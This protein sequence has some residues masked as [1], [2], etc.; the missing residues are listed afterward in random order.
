MYFKTILFI[1]GLIYFGFVLPVF[2]QYSYPQITLKD[3]DSYD[4]SEGIFG[5]YTGGDFYFAQNKFWANNVGQ[6]GITSLGDIG[7]VSLYNVEI[8]QQGFSRF[9][10]NAEKGHTYVSLARQGEEGNYI[11]FRIDNVNSDR[12]ILSYAYRTGLP[13]NIDVTFNFSKVAS[14]VDD[15]RERAVAFHS[16]TYIDSL[17]QPLEEVIFGTADINTVQG[18]GWYENETS[19]QQ[20]LF[21]WAGG[22]ALRA[23]VKLTVPSQTKGLLLKIAAVKDSIMMNVL[24]DQTV[25]DTL[26]VDS[27]WHSGFV[28][29]GYPYQEPVPGEQPVWT[30]GRYFPKFQSTDRIFVFPALTSIADNSSNPWDEGWRINQSY[31]DLMALTLVGMQGLINRSRPRVYLDWKD[32]FATSGFWVSHIS[33]QI[34][35]IEMDLD[36]L[37]AVNFL[38]KRFKTLFKGI[39]IYDPEIP[40]TINLATMLAGKDDLLILAPEQLDLPGIT[41]LGP[42]TDLQQLALSQGW[43][44]SVES[45]TLIYQWAYDNIWPQLEHRILGIITPGPPTSGTLDNNQM[46]PLNL[47]QRDYYVALRLSAIYL[48]PDTEP[49]SG[50]LENFFS[51]APSPVPVTGG[52]SI[53]EE[54]LTSFISRHGDWQMALSWPGQSLSAGNLSVFSG[55]ETDVKKY[56]PEMDTGRIFATLGDR[57][58]ATMFCTDGDNLQY[59]TDR[60]FHDFFVWEDVQNQRFGWTINPTL[61]EIAPIVWNYYVENR[62]DVSLVSGLSGAGY[63]YPQLMDSEQLDK[64]LDY[65][66]QYFSD[67]GLRVN[68]ADDRKGPW[69]KQLAV[70]YYNKL[71]DTGYMGT[72]A[73]YAGGSRQGIA[74]DYYGVPTPS[75]RPGYQIR[76]ENEQAVVNDI[77]SRAAGDDIADIDYEIN[78]VCNLVTD[79]DAYNNQAILIPPSFSYD[80][81]CCLATN[82]ES[83]VLAPGDY[84]ATFRLKV[85]TNEDTNPVANIYLGVSSDDWYHIAGQYIA[86]ADFIQSNVYQDFIIPF[87]LDTLTSGFECRIDHWMG[88]QTELYADYFKIIRSGGP[89][90][91]SFRTVLVPLIINVNEMPYQNSAAGRFTDIFESA[92]GIVLTADEY[93]AALNPEYMLDLATPILG[94][95][96]QVITKAQQELSEKN[97]LGSLITIREGLRPLVVSTVAIVPPEIANNISETDSFEVLINDVN[98]LA[99]FQFEIKFDPLIARVDT[100]T[101]APF[102]NSTERPF[103]Q[104][105]IV[106]DNIQGSILVGISTSGDL[107]GASGAGALIKVLFTSLQEGE[108]SFEFKNVQIFN[109][110]GQ[111][112]SIGN[113]ETGFLYVSLAAH[114]TSE[115]SLP[116]KFSLSQNYPNPFNPITRIDYS[117]PKTE[118]VEIVIYNISGQKVKVLVSAQHSAGRYTI[119]WDGTNNLAKQVASGIYFYQAT[120]G[121]NSNIKKMIFIK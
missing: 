58:V 91:P 61:P 94:P 20:G 7:E 32:T 29:V 3:G 34:D 74:V 98:E 51:D 14:T 27:Y 92:G 30:E 56:Q 55:I 111:I 28:T 42:V 38:L 100:I 65:T 22:E 67:T 83:L 54:G 11:I 87:T 25:A 86:P 78:Q 89:A 104:K 76:G 57:P 10:I 5:Q 81:S 77:L 99:A 6:R 119:T 72:I 73:G 59:L 116:Q 71:K 4:F 48:D 118:H 105:D 93:L 82:T 102:L 19:V 45:Q 2:A 108:T 97:F 66:A 64:Y 110:D 120:A 69:G 80:E 17:A 9:G 33:E 101:L 49:Q 26:R 121:K 109:G 8:P 106:V 60:G 35:V 16:I 47:A 75:V 96:H 21:Q 41:D 50:L 114:I 37:S 95:G 40:E 15:S 36:A 63:M 53:K 113:L 107:P 39:V 117:I 24:I 31:K 90:L 85:S 52:F 13:F 62:T 103:S 18:D 46:W 23:T 44:A 115:I 68:R 70:S 84:T 112:L 12:V 79:D 1:Y 88:T 43:D